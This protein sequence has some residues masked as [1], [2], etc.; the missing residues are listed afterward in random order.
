MDVA[1]SRPGCAPRTTRFFTSA[2]AVHC[3]GF[4]LIELLVAMAIL[5]ILAA[6]AIPSIKD[7]INGQRK[8]AHMNTLA[9]SLY[10]ARSEAIMRNSDVVICK[11]NNGATCTTNGEWEQGWIV[12]EDRDSDKKHDADEAVLARQSRLN[13]ITLYYRAFGSNHYIVYRSQGI[14]KTNG[15]YTFCDSGGSE[16]ARALII[17]KTGRVR[18]SATR[19]DGSPLTCPP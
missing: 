12:F 9:A 19:S 18:P 15:T 7:F 6:N 3:R 2:I 13:G 17:Y 10:L 4:T 14:T 8:I 1:S 16:S 5:I 11:S